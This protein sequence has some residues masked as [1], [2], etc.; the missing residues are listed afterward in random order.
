MTGAIF[1]VQVEPAISRVA[2]TKR[3][4]KRQ[5]YLAKVPPFLNTLLLVL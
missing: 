2:A 5:K 1:N 3:C 4:G